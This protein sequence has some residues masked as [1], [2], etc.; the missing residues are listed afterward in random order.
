MCFK[1]FE[2]GYI[3]ISN[4]I[5]DVEDWICVFEW[6][7]MIVK[8]LWLYVGGDELIFGDWC[9]CFWL[10]IVDLLELC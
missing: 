10:K 2:G 7:L 1:K 6:D 4:F 5:L 8:W 3:I 9:W